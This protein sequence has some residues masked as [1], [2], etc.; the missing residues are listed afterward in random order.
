MYQSFIVAVNAVMPFVVYISFGY[1]IKRI[2]IVDEDLL[3]KINKMSF[4]AFYPFM[5]FN[6]LYSIPEGY[7]VSLS[8]ILLCLFITVVMIV[9]LLKTIPNL[10]ELKEDQYS[11]VVRALYHSNLLFFALPMTVNVFG[12]KYQGTAAAVLTAVVP[13]YNASSVYVLERFRGGT[14]DPLKLFKKMLTNPLVL[15]ALCGLALRMLGIRLP[16]WLSKPVAGFAGLVTPLALFILGGTLKFTAVGKNMKIILQTLLIKLMILPGLLILLGIVLRLDPIYKFLLLCLASTPVA[17]STYAMSEA[18]G[19]DVELTG[20]F[21]VLST[22][23]AVFTMFF[24]I[25]L[26]ST[27]G[28]L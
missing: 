1:L 11:V 20:H 26:M 5:T 24:W 2:G 19:A 9:V 21:V 6:S 7:K 28:L 4:V 13:F 22:V 10:K 27:L 23:I 25:F 17:T 12:E 3:H 18:M 14:A 16:V 8:F 15:G